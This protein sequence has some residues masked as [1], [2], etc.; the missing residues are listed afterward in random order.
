MPETVGLGKLR[1]SMRRPRNFH[2]ALL[3]ICLCCTVGVCLLRAYSVR[4]R[5][6]EWE[7]RDLLARYGRKAKLDPRIVFIG[8]DNQSLDAVFNE[9]LDDHPALPLMKASGFPYPRNVYPLILERLLEA[10]AKVVALDILFPASRDGDDAFQAAL[11]KYRDR[12]V[13]GANLEQRDQGDWQSSERL[14]HAL[15][16]PSASLIG[17]PSPGITMDERTGYVNFWPDSDQKVRHARYTTSL[18]ALDRGEKTHGDG[19]EEIYYSLTAR[20]LQKAG[21]SQQIPAGSEPVLFRYATGIRPVSL[22]QIFLDRIWQAPPFNGGEFFRDKLVLIGPDGNWVKD[23]LLTPF[24][25]PTNGPRIHL[26]ALNAAL[27]GDFL[28]EGGNLDF[29]AIAAAGLAAWALGRFVQRRLVRFCA[30]ILLAC[31]FV[32]AAFLAFDHLGVWTIVLSPLLAL[33]LPGFTYSVVEQV[34][35][36]MEKNRVRRTLER[37]V[38]K[39]VVKE[40]LDNPESFLNSLGG[41]R[42]PATV[43]FSD[44]RG[45][46]SATENADPTQLVLQLNE[47]FEEMVRIVRVVE[48]GTLDK[49][50]GDGLMAHWGSIVSEGLETDARRAVS[51]ALQMRKALPRLNKSWAERGML[52]FAIGIGVN[53]GDVIV[54]NI[55]SEEK[56]EPTAIGDPVNLAARLEGVTKPYGIDLCIGETAANLVKEWFILRSLDLIVVK[57]KKKPVECFAVLDERTEGAVEPEWLPKHEQAARLY[58][59]GDFASAERLWR[60]VLS[61]QPEDGISKVFIERCV[62]L[63]QEPPEGEWTGVFEMKSK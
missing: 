56:M 35:D 30:L 20:M 22:H 23:E 60:E 61:A 21:F 43:L 49:F 47:Y 46:T 26:S 24:K 31:G 9:E 17:L 36:F 37:Y 10:G 63:Q 58:R 62:E 48:R 29:V 51:A 59:S 12:A 11:D 42:K 53:T 18:F 45:F 39:D 8:I 50:I 19:G 38:S 15:V 6:L 33:L 55:G 54:G 5:N 27:T 34:F 25:Q 7:T 52:H 40:V 44:V 3:L 57:G 16:P 41:K 4:Y 2:L 28:R 32:G 13:I 1:R 14:R